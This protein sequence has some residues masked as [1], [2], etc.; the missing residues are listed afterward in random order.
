MFSDDN[1]SLATQVEINFLCYVS[2]G[3]WEFPKKVNEKLGDMMFVFIGPVTLKSITKCEYTFTKAVCIFH[4]I[5]IFS[6]YVLK[7]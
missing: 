1:D 2:G 4:K 5:L 7:S 3:Y 6:T